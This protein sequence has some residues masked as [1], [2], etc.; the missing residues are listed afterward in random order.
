MKT[1]VIYYS[2]EGSS[3]RIAEAIKAAIKADVFEIKTT[4]TKKRTGFSKY[5]WG[6]GQVVFGKK[7]PIFPL[8][9]DPNAY[10]LIILGTPV[11]AGSP[12]PAML[13]FLDKTKIKGKKLAFF[14][15]HGGGMGKVFEKLKALLPGN[16]FAGEIDFSA[17]DDSAAVKQRISEWLKSIGA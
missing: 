7:P 13:S 12:A 11:W 2:F 8:P 10:D 16:N 5:V 15:C 3:A 17:K 9:L 4:D 6:G 1:A 14:C